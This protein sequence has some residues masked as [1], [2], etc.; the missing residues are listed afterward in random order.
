MTVQTEQLIKEMETEK[1]IKI[2]IENG[3]VVKAINVPENYKVEIED[4]TKIYKEEN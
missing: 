4:D 1:T 3:I 2:V